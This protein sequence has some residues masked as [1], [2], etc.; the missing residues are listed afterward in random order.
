MIYDRQSRGEKRRMHGQTET[1]GSRGTG[2]LVRDRQTDRQ[3]QGERETGRQTDRQTDRQR[4]RETDRQAGRQAGRQ[5]DRQTDRQGETDRQIVSYFLDFKVLSTAQCWSS[6]E[7]VTQPKFWYFVTSKYVAKSQVRSWV[8]VLN[9]TETREIHCA[10]LLRWT[11]EIHCATFGANKTE[12]EKDQRGRNK[13]KR[14]KRN[15]SAR[16]S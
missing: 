13:K 6:Q 4:Q 8:A 15:R 12:D 2:H 3:R 16:Y 9:T 10:M 1:G 5:T 14:K 7:Q 11:R